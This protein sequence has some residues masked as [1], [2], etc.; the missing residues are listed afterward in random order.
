MYHTQPLSP[1][2]SRGLVRRQAAQAGRYERGPGCY[3]IR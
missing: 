3:Q 2:P 1:E